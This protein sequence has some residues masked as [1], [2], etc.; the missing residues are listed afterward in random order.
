MRNSKVMLCQNSLGSS[1]PLFV[2]F[3]LFYNCGRLLLKLPSTRSDA[4]KDD[5]YEIRAVVGHLA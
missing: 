1:P 3:L 5:A 2:S 4:R